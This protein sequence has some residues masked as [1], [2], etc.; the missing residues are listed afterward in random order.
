MNVDKPHLPETPWE[1]LGELVRETV[2]VDE[3]K[4]FLD[5]PADSDRLLD[6]PAIRQA[7]GKDKYMPYWA[8]LWP[9]AR[10]LARAVLREAWPEGATALELGCGLGLPGIVALARGLRVIFSDCDRT[11]VRM[12]GEN[13]TLNGF[14]NFKLL[15]M[16]W[17]FPPP[18]LQVPI[19]LASD[20]A[21]ERRHVDP[22]VAVI[23]AVLA[24]DGLCLLTDQDRPPAP[25]L[26][27]M[28]SANGL[29]FTTEM[30]RAG[31]PGARRHKGT[32]YRIRRKT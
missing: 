28:L 9:A 32:L 25:Y 13:A 27:E 14:T 11:A 30:M 2:I 18:G 29:V 1:V 8:D 23:T 19:V 21:F 20:L 10:M 4:F 31:E 26:R 5:R 7:F 16:D 24:P 6:H 15:P 17:R 22:L 3:R 12:A